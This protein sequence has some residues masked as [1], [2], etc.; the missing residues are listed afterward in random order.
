M[1]T[2]IRKYNTGLL[3]FG[4]YLLLVSFALLVTLSDM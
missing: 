3:T 2:F 4:I 1:S